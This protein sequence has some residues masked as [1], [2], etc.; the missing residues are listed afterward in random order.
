MA[1]CTLGAGSGASVSET[2]WVCVR[3]SSGGPS[4]KRAAGLQDSTPD[5][6][7]SEGF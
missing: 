5:R 3:G 6:R 4:L 7:G 2:R 1:V